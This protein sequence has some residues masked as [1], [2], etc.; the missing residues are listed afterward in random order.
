[1]ARYELHSLKLT[2]YGTYHM[3]L[4]TAS[5]LEN[6]PATNRQRTIDYLSLKHVMDTTTTKKLVYDATLKK[7]EAIN[8][9]GNI[10]IGPKAFNQDRSWL[11]NVIF[12]EIVHS[13][14]FS[15]YEV[16][17]VSFSHVESSSETE[18]IIVAFDELESYYRTWRNSAALGL[19]SK[20][21]SALKR[22]VE[23]RKIDVGDEELL[24]LASKEGFEAA[25]LMLIRKLKAGS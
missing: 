9:K 2:D 17:G 22:E 19:S 18:R 6:A 12:H 7:Q 5:F 25:R 4:V 13:D 21:T 8:V 10:T 16:N 24:K 11:A 3:L 15:F 23:L 1:M 14:Q 20:Q